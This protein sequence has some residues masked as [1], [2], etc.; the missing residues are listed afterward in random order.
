MSQKSFGLP[1]RF[2]NMVDVVVSVVV[3]VALLLIGN[4]VN[5]KESY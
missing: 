1:S 4:G 5:E 2:C 3:T